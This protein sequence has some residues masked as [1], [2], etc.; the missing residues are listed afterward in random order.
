MKMAYT[1]GGAGVVK[2]RARLARQGAPLKVALYASDDVLRSDHMHTVR[3]LTHDVR[4]ESNKVLFV[5]VP[6]WQDP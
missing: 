4:T 3:K 1:A 2:A 6:N 5:S